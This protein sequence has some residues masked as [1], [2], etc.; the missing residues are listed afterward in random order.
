MKKLLTL[1]FLAFSLVAFAKDEFP[2]PM[3]PPRLVNDFA[4]ILSPQEQASLESKLRRYEDSTS[5]QIAIVTVTGLGDWHIQEY[6]TRLFEQ[7]GIGKKGKDNGILILVAPNERKVRIETGYGLEGALPDLV[8]RRIISSYITPNFKSGNYYQGLNEASSKLIELSS[9]EYKA[10]PK[11][12]LLLS[13]GHLVIIFLFF[14]IFFVSI[15][16]NYRK[17]KN[18]QIGTHGTSFW[19]IWAM[20]NLFG[21]GGGSGNFNDFNRGGGDFG[22]FGG[23]MSGGGGADG[24]W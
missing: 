21:H 23:G 15:F 16:V 22:G 5:S 11:T 18:Q 6:A 3:N 13:N 10:G 17:F 14:L 24:D 8:Q 7:W 19:T 2:K 20:S 12:K 9:G 4:G 1:L